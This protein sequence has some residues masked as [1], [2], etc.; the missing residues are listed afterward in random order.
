MVL[1]ARVQTSLTLVHNPTMDEYT[2]NNMRFVSYNCHGYND[3]KIPC[4]SQLLHQCKFCFIQEHWFANCQLHRLNNICST[5]NS[6]AISG[7]NDDDIISGRPYGGCAILWRADLDVTVHFVETIN[8]R[9]CSIQV[10]NN[11]YKLLLINVYMPYESDTAAADEFSSVLADVIAITEQYGDHC[12]VIGGDFNV[13]FNKHKVHSK[14]L[15][16]VCNVND[17]RVATLHDSCNVDFT[18][19]FNMDRVSFIDHFIV[20][21][22]V[23]ET[24][25]GVC[26]VRHDGD[27]LSHH[28]PVLLSLNVDWNLFSSSPRQYSN[29][30]IWHKASA[31]D[32]V[33]YKL[34]SVQCMFQ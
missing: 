29:K 6:H 17:L 2:I 8:K 19:N 33:L 24:C 13:D 14:L 23:Y 12:T 7:F 27:N 16:D 34:I 10:Y 31:K 15:Q 1:F 25:F 28:D 3:S 5:H 22:T 21:A 11:K 30:C 26:S 9:I 18:Y 4:M 20:P 32:L